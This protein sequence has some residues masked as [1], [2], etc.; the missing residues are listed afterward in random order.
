MTC[1][2]Q[3][4]FRLLVYSYMVRENMHGMTLVYTKRGGDHTPYYT[5]TNIGMVTGGIRGMEMAAVRSLHDMLVVTV[6]QIIGIATYG[7]G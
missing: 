6:F 7:E 4:C 5:P 1:F 3:L 2:M